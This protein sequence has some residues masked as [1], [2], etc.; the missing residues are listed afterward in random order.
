MPSLFKGNNYDNSNTTLQNCR[1]IIKKHQEL[2][3]NLFLIEQR[4]SNSQKNYRIDSQGHLKPSHAQLLFISELTTNVLTRFVCLIVLP[5]T[6]PC[7]A[8]SAH[9]SCYSYSATAVSYQMFV[10]DSPYR[11]INCLFI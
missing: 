11:Y 9:I 6:E 4:E 5:P 8:V 7:Q 2:L 1:K 10:H 3:Q